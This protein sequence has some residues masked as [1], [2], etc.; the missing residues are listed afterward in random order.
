MPRQR[1]EREYDYSLH[2]RNWHDESDVHASQMCESYRNLLGAHLPQPQGKSLLDIGCGMG[3]AL[4]TMREYG[5]D[6]VQGIDV[7]PEQIDACKRLGEPGE[8]VEDACEYLSSCHREFDVVLLLDVLEHVPTSGQIELMRAVAAVLAPGGRAI[9]T[10]PNASSPLASRQRYID[11]THY[12]AFT[13]YS[14]RFVLVNAGFSRIEVPGQGPRERPP[15]RFWRRSFR[16][17]FRRWVVRMLWRQILIAEAN[18]PSV[19]SICIELNL[20]CVAF[21]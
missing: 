15:L 19:D 2:Y 18:D 20:F 4:R 12:S 7:S 6:H 9:L 5:F 16:P 10:V 11:F 3:F 13:E 17:A 1:L 8:L 21:K 14:L